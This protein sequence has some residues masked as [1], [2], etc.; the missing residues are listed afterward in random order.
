MHTSAGNYIRKIS[1]IANPQNFLPRNFVAITV[2]TLM[3]I[4]SIATMR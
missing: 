4:V 1:L 2:S 3:P